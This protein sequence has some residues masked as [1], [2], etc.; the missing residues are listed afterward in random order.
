MFLD[1]F[2]CFLLLFRVFVI[3]LGYRSALIRRAASCTASIRALPDFQASR[4]GGAL[5]ARPQNRPRYPHPA[6]PTGDLLRTP[7]TARP[8]RPYELPPVAARRRTMRHHTPNCRAWALGLG[9]IRPRSQVVGPSLGRGFR[10]GHYWALR[11]A[12]VWAWS[13]CFRGLPSLPRPGYNYRSS[14]LPGRSA[15]R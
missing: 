11:D 2:S 7:T 6:C 9:P 8:D 10:P 14:V 15:V 3:V 1:R 4:P 13:R 12:E 5:L